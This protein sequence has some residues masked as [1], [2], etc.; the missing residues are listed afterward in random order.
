MKKKKKIMLPCMAAVAIAMFVGAKVMKPNAIESNGL[1]L[2]NVE[3]LSASE[4]QDGWDCYVVKDPCILR[5]STNAQL[6]F[7]K[8]YL[9]LGNITI[10][11]SID[12]TDQTKVFKKLTD[13]MKKAGVAGVECGT[14]VYCSD[15]KSNIGW[16]GA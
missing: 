9:N 3:A 4:Y 6:S 12:R 8:K 13:Q 2:T 16:P 7:M 15:L 1:L 14:S 5:V 10:G 11:Y